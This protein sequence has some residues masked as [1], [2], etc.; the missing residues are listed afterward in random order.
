M[1]L[2]GVTRDIAFAH[3]PHAAP[4]NKVAVHVSATFDAAAPFLLCVF[5]H[6]LSGDVPFEDHIR[7]AIAQFGQGTANVVLVAPR[8]GDRSAPG[9]FHDPAGFPALL[10]ELQHVLPK[11]LPLGEEA[12]ARAP[13]VLAVFSGGWRPLTAVLNGLLASASPCADRI[14]GILLLDSVFG[15]LSSAAVIAWQQKRRAQVALLSIYGRDT[16]DNARDSNLALIEALKP[17][18]P[19]LTPASWDDVDAFPSG[20]IVFLEVT[21]PH[22]DITS[23][24]PPAAPIAA[25]LDRLADVASV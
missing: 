23:D 13:I 10:D 18:G 4:D 11:M 21:T 1:P 22:I 14:K 25:F 9:A 5:M 15:P 3:A 17:T 6:G 20:T 19:V 12:V 8:F 16:M 24:G 7:R 2:A